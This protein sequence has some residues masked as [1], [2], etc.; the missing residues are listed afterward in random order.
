MAPGRA[1]SRL[2]AMHGPADSLLALACLA[3][4]PFLVGRAID[5]SIGWPARSN[6][7]STVAGTSAGPHGNPVSGLVAL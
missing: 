1:F 6:S 5:P 4:V 3:I 2:Q 7:W